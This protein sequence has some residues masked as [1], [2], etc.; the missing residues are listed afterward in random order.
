MSLYRKSATL[1]SNNGFA[2]FRV[3]DDRILIAIEGTLSLLSQDTGDVLWQFSD[4]QEKLL[5]FPKVYPMTERVFAVASNIEEN[6]KIEH[7]WPNAPASAIICLDLNNGRPLWKNTQVASKHIGQLMYNDGC[8]GLFG[9]GGIGAGQSPFTGCIRTSDNK[10]I[11][12]GTFPTAWNHA[13]YV[14]LWRDGRM[15]YADPWKIFSLDPQTG[16]ETH[17]YGLEP[18]TGKLIW[19]RTLA[20][21]P[22]VIAGTERIDSRIVPNSVLNDVLQS[23]GD[24]L[25]LPAGRNIRFIFDPRMTDS[26]LRQKLE[27]NSPKEKH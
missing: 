26:Q 24:L 20:K 23:D 5:L 4:P 8:L 11:W 17:V 10:L 3:F 22:A 19:K 1:P 6:Y 21:S 2:S 16:L 7:R 15:Y 13:G 14:M 18:E 27:T 9:P 25:S 12:T